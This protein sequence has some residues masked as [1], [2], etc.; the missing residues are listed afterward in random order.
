VS[1]TTTADL[2]RLLDRLHRG[3]DA[4]RR[5]IL[6]R[7]Y[8]RLVQIAAAVYRKDF[9]GLRGRHDVESVVSELWIRLARALD[10]THPSTVKGFFGLVFVNVRQ[11]LID[12]V[13]K[14]RRHDARRENGPLDSNESDALADFDRPDTTN[15][16]LRL[17]VLTEVHKQIQLLPA[18]ERQVFELRYYGGYSQAE[19]A[20]ILDLHPRKVSRLWHTAT[21][22]LAE[23]LGEFGGI[24]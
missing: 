4:A 12:L 9:P 24:V 5:A 10:A 7:A 11:I 1:G 16:P 19:I 14:E 22:R 6:D 17:V 15:D 20:Q 18:E 8:H 23:W 21:L 3:D 2:A 13:R